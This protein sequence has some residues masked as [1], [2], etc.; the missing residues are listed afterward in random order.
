MRQPLIIVLTVIFV[1]SIGIVAHAQTTKPAEQNS[2]ASTTT[3]H[4]TTTAT[5]KDGEQPNEVEQMVAEAKKHGEMVLGAC[6]DRCAENANKAIDGFESG[7]AL[8]LPKPAYPA[9]ARA[10]HASGTVEVKVLIGFDGKVIAAVAVSGHPLLY[11]AS[12]QAARAAEFTPM[13]LNGQPVKITGIIQYNF[14]AR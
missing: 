4:A 1:S 13:K 9:L 3:E 11:G 6:I 7:H 8:S 2:T 12:V 10:A 14:V 5:N